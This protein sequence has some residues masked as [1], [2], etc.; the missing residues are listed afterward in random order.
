MKVYSINYINVLTL[1]SLDCKAAFSTPPRNPDT[2]VGMQFD[3]LHS[4][5]YAMT[6]DDLL[7]AIT[8][9]RKD[10]SKD[11]WPELRAEIFSKGQPCLR[12]SSLPKTLGWALHHNADG[13]VALIDVGTPAYKALMAD[14][15]VE[16][17]P[18]MR[19]KRA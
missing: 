6:S 15:T 14:E 16:K 2:V 4:H 3:M 18:A 12:T 10:I 13:R 8:G 17:R 5:P 9:T 7:V 19:N 11:E 1:P